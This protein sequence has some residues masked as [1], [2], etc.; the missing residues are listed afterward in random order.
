MGDQPK[1]KGTSDDP[2]TTPRPLDRTLRARRPS[3]HRSKQKSSGRTKGRIGS[4]TAA[5]QKVKYKQC[6]K[7]NTVVSHEGGEGT[8]DSK[9]V[10]GV[11]EDE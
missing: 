7:E 6:Q 4:R 2:G 5:W 1:G 9:V 3:T 10:R 8:S 11:S